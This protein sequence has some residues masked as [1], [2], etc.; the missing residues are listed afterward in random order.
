MYPLNTT[1]HL[2]YLAW[3]KAFFYLLIIYKKS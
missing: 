1:K 2:D 3:R